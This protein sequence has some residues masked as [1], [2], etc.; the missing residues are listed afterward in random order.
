[1]SSNNSI[2]KIEDI[3]KG[4]EDHTFVVTF[5]ATG[6]GK[7]TML[8]GLFS[9]I[10]TSK[11]RTIANV[12]DVYSTQIFL[13][14]SRNLD[15]YSTLPE[16]TK[17]LSA[18]EASGLNIQYSDLFLQGD[19]IETAKLTFFE[20]S[21]EDWEVV[22]PKFAKELQKYRAR[23]EAEDKDKK[24][25][26]STESRRKKSSFNRRK[27]AEPK[28]EATEEKT[29]EAK[30]DVIQ[31]DYINKKAELARVI[32]DIFLQKDI[33][34]L[35]IM[36][37]DVTEAR[38]Q[39]DLLFTFLSRLKNKKEEDFMVDACSLVLAKWD[40]V[41]GEKK[42]EEILKTDLAR[43]NR[44]IEEI[45]G[46]EAINFSIGK[47]DPSDKLKVADLNLS[48]VDNILE[49]I[50]KAGGYEKKELSIWEQFK[51]WWARNY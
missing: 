17:A 39:D 2:S 42:I 37:V 38:M 7:T 40:L 14:Y 1:M 32:E 12:N 3:I 16:E 45:P 23:K 36:A 4:R 25:E 29:K 43:S 9:Y 5:G 10:R 8:A 15:L 48:Y 13:E 6:S 49:W 41:N 51:A 20:I 21:G 30:E 46:S 33:P 26:A 50:L 31:S 24:T 47:I 27:E 11:Y 34:V 35:L 19:D 22:D 18:I 28:G 44:I